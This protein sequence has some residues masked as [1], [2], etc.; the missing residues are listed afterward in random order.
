MAVRCYPR[1]SGLCIS[2]RRRGYFRHEWRAR[3]NVRKRGSGMQDDTACAAHLPPVDAYRELAGIDYANHDLREVL[4]R[5]AAVAKRTLVPRGEVSVTLVRGSRA[6]TAAY[7][8]ATALELD[9]TQYGQ[10]L[11]PCL[12]AAVSA[13][14]LHIPD[15]A[16]ESRWP[17]YAPIAAS[18]GVRSAVSI[19]L[20]IQEA[21]VGALN[22]Y[23]PT[24]EFFDE[25]A[26]QVVAGFAAYA[27][28]AA[29]NAHL[30]DDAASQARQ[31]HEAMEHRAVIEQAKGII[32]GDRRCGAEEAFDILR[33]LSNASNRELRDVAVTLVAEAQ[34]RPSSRRP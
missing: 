17:G 5:V 6:Y 10:G 34:K 12:D 29:A 30:Y 33:G 9:Q 24:P 15:M 8:G 2:P 25:P 21:V 14:L 31:M 22:L 26:L 28:V 20:P 23:E 3:L 32:M 19:G 16:A 13:E 7:T 4:Q 11:G 18:R 1:G 27:A